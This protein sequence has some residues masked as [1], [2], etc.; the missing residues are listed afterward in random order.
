MY[1]GALY[2]FRFVRFWQ[3]LMQCNAGETGLKNSHVD[4]HIPRREGLIFQSVCIGLFI[5]FPFSVFLIFQTF[6]YRIDDSYA[7]NAVVVTEI[8][9]AEITVN[10]ETKKY[11]FSTRPASPIL[12]K[13]TGKTQSSTVKRVS[14]C[15][16]STWNYSADRQRPVR[17][18]KRFDIYMSF[19]FQRDLTAIFSSSL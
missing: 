9:K 12:L 5:L 14:S 3:L 15:P 10:G 1:A 2:V 17:I 8:D 6:S 18:N 7:G 4:F 11:S 13:C 16:M 19:F